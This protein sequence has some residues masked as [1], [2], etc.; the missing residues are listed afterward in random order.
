MQLYKHS[1]RPYWQT[2]ST[3]LSINYSKLSNQ[4]N[5]TLKTAAKCHLF[6]LSKPFNLFSLSMFQ[7]LFILTRFHIFALVH[8]LVSSKWMP[9]A[10]A[11]P[12]FG[13]LPYPIAKCTTSTNPETS[14]QWESSHAQK[15]STKN[16]QGFTPV[17]A[18]LLSPTMRCTT[19]ISQQSIFPCCDTQHPSTRLQQTHTITLHSIFPLTLV[20]TSC[21]WLM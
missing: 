11:P 20:K 15:T 8:F 13:S 4:F 3:Y 1:Q 18:W 10:H 9:E 16:P 21:L 17:W 5:S 19:Q 14:N 6:C 12:R 7:G 2:E